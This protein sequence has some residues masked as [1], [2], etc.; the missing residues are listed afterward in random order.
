MRDAIIRQL[1]IS[2]AEAEARSFAGAAEQMRVSPAA[3]SFPIKQIEDMS[4]FAMF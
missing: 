1:K 4:G 2:T 3:V